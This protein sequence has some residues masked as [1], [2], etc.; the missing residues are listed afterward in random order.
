MPWIYVV[1]TYIQPSDYNGYDYIKLYVADDKNATSHV[2]TIQF[3]ILESP[4]QNKGQC[5]G[6]YYFYEI[7]HFFVL[8]T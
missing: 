5:Q 2:V 1:V 7:L 4:C 8:H 3:V 6:Y